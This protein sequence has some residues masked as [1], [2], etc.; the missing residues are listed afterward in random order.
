M[1]ESIGG[2]PTGEPTPVDQEA[3]LDALQAAVRS[4]Q[5][6]GRAQAEA[7]ELGA[8]SL[9]P[10]AQS[11]GVGDPDL[12]RIREEVRRR[13]AERGEPLLPQS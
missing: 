6:K 11:T 8:D 3:A 9:E 7:S 1:V 5:L 13:Q 12:A 2:Q 4:N 10:P